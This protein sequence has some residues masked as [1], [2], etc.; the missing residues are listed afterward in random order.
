MTSHTNG[1]NGYGEGCTGPHESDDYYKILDNTTA[2]ITINLNEPHY[3]SK[4]K[5]DP[6]FRPSRHEKRKLLVKFPDEEDERVFEVG[7]NIGEVGSASIDI[8]K[9]LK[10]TKSI[11]ISG[12][13]SKT[14]EDNTSRFGYNKIELFT[15]VGKY[16]RISILSNSLESYFERK[17]KSKSNS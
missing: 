3:I 16:S 11:E 8:K 13:T 9:P 5:F 15:C 4:I 10:W 17:Y 1:Y 2:W 12:I 6:K 14:F 7:K